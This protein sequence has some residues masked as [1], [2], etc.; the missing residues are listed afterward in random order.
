[1]IFF[2]TDFVIINFHLR[3]SRKEKC[4]DIFIISPLICL[5][6]F[7]KPVVNRYSGKIVRPCHANWS[8]HHTNW[9]KKTLIILGK[10]S[11]TEGKPNSADHHQTADLDLH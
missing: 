10:I 7:Q 11:S 6:Y 3:N 9:E 4:V 1:M 5:K 8:V 2:Y